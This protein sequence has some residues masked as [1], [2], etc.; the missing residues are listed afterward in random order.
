MMSRD[1]IGSY[2]SLILFT[3]KRVV[4]RVQGPG[5]AQYHLGRSRGWEGRMQ[6][7]GKEQEMGREDAGQCEGAGR[8]GE[9]I[10]R[11]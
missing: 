4:R 3:A 2:C 11:E 6:V 1:R 7:R 5:C 9:G 8:E 10:G